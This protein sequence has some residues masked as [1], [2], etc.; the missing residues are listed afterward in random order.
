MDQFNQAPA[1]TTEEFNDLS[2]TVSSLSDSISAFSARLE[3]SCIRTFGNVGAATELTFVGTYAEQTYFIFGSAAQN[4]AV[5][6]VVQTWSSG[7]YA[8]NYG[9]GSV[10]V[11]SKSGN[12]IIL[13]VPQ[14]YRGCIISHMPFTTSAR[15]PT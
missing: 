9:S 5:L 8:Y 6:S 12:T 3:N 11:K 15:I 2:D 7:Y 1:P 14:W 13:T 4:V 10:T